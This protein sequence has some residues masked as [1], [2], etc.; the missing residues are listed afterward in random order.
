VSEDE[1]DDNYYFYRAAM[2]FLWPVK[3]IWNI[4]AIAIAG[5][6]F[7]YQ[8]V[9]ALRAERRVHEKKAKAKKEE[10]LARGGV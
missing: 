4:M 3:F 10:A 6:D 5:P 2:F 1:F 8:A 9:K 7:A